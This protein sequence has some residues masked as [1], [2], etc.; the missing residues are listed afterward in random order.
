MFPSEV[1]IV[2]Y[3]TNTVLAG[4]VYQAL[5]EADPPFDEASAIAK[6]SENQYR[7]ETD[8]NKIFF[9]NESTAVKN[10]P[11]EGGSDVVENHKSKINTK[12]PS[13]SK[14]QST[15]RRQRPSRRG[16]QAINSS[17]VPIVIGDEEDVI[18]NS[19]PHFPPLPAPPKEASSP[20]FSPRSMDS[21]SDPPDTPRRS[22]GAESLKSR[23]HPTNSLPPTSVSSKQRISRIPHAT[24]CKTS[25][26]RTWLNRSL[27]DQYIPGSPSPSIPS[28]PPDITGSNK[29]LGP[30]VA[31]QGNKGQ[32]GLNIG[33]QSKLNSER[34]FV[35][36]DDESSELNSLMTNEIE[37]NTMDTQSRLDAVQQDKLDDDDDDDVVVVE[38][39]LEPKTHPRDNRK[40]NQRF[41]PEATSKCITRSS[42]K[43]EAIE[44]DSSV[45][46][47]QDKNNKLPQLPQE[48]RISSSITKILESP[49]LTLL[50]PKREN[51]WQVENTVDHQ[52]D[53]S[54]RKHDGKSNKIRSWS[55]EL[56]SPVVEEVDSEEEMEVEM[57][58][59]EIS[60]P[61]STAK[62]SRRK[63]SRM[64]EEEEEEEEEPLEGKKPPLRRPKSKRKKNT[65]YTVAKQDGAGGEQETRQKRRRF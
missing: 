42:L 57:E 30:H 63:T 13:P 3:G 44:D 5:Q 56:S 52:L 46:E 48:Q 18:N 60:P 40:Q 50:S 20:F 32:N 64:A 54:V 26:V 31:D 12:P 41:S 27:R 62:G 36:E 15:T 22:I 25:D 45:E 21:V 11:K 7:P 23:P 58:L 33:T 17:T 10:A 16:S 34:L 35:D 59:Q 65:A 51:N 49:P 4:Q 6:L 53:L 47:I 28:S 38:C 55:E 29:L 1:G 19:S 9:G 37:T 24:P 14:D 43:V 39:E 8:I 61:L 2:S